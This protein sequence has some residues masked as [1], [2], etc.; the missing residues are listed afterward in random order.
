MA[1]PNVN[2]VYFN[3]FNHNKGVFFDEKKKRFVDFYDMDINTWMN[4]D[5]PFTNVRD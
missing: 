4:Y 3:F 1:N 5:S 2:K